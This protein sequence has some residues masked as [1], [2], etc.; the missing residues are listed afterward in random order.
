MNYATMLSKMH[1][2]PIL[3]TSPEKLSEFLTGLG[4]KVRS[5]E[6]NSL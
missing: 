6:G 5:N 1:I 2:E 4:K 3:S